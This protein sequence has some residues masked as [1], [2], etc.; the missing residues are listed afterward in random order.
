MV[1]SEQ[2]GSGSSRLSRV[3]GI[4]AE[5]AA[6]VATGVLTVADL[7]AVL[8]T[9]AEASRSKDGTKGAEVEGPAVEVLPGIAWA[10][11]E[12]G[13]AGALPRRGGV[14]DVE[15]R[16]GNTLVPGSLVCCNSKL[17]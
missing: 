13:G 8:Q 12:G 9:G 14:E 5:A 2:V 1:G 10:D 16:G 17:G 7:R 4:E 11:I 15:I 3:A 6:I